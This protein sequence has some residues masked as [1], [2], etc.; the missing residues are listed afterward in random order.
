MKLTN[1]AI[2][3]AIGK[4]ADAPDIVVDGAVVT[5]T[6]ATLDAYNARTSADTEALRKLAAIT[7]ASARDDGGRQVVALTFGVSNG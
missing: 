7:A 3:K 6:Y 4:G 2:A 1:E 5:L